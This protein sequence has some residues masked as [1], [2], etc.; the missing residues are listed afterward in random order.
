MVAKSLTHRAWKGRRGPAP[1]VPPAHLQWVGGRGWRGPWPH[2]PLSA[3]LQI[4]LVRSCCLEPGNGGSHQRTQAASELG[5]KI[6][7]QSRHSAAASCEGGG[8]EEGGREGWEGREVGVKITCSQ[9]LRS[10]F[11]SYG[12]IT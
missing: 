3:A 7:F 10:T 1:T 9:V 12:S 5:H 8:G 2:L 6:G 4:P 11:G